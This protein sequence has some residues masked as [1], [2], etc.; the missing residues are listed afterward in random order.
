[1]SSILSDDT[2]NNRIWVRAEKKLNEKRVAIVPKDAE[3][4]IKAG[5]EVT[6]EQSGQRCIDISAY[7]AVGCN[8]AEEG[9]W[10]Q[11]PT[12]T[13]VLGV[14]EL[15]AGDTHLNHRHIYFG[16]VFKDQP[17][18]EHTLGRFIK[19]QGILYDLECLVD[20]NDRRIAAFG[21]WAGYAGAAAA[22]MAWIGQQA[23]NVPPVGPIGSYPN[24]EAL[25]GE[26][27]GGLE[28]AGDKPTMIVIGALGRT[29]SGATDLGIALG[30]EITKWDMAE[31]ASGGPFPEIQNHSIFVNCIL[32]SKDCPRFVT[33]D[34]IRVPDRRLSVIADVSCDPESAYNPI[35]V[36]N[37]STTFDAPTVSVPIE[38]RPLDVVAI[39]HLPSM[40]PLESSEDYSR[41]LMTAL[42]DLKE[43]E[44]GIWGRALNQFNKNVKRLD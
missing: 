3:T 16:H 36:Y 17:G 1:M 29:G 14:K 25:L 39:D 34:D 35:P 9:S 27:R 24:V 18:W 22:V 31:T 38:G 21:Y 40:L 2:A 42:M 20:E 26:L 13:F 23:G 37:R 32:A 6:V 28:N 43:P 10:P 33:A 19:G 5:Y 11:A 8:I 12:D 44:K 41:Q 4:L 7:E 30:L 15:P